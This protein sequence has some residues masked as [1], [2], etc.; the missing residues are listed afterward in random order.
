MK[1]KVDADRIINHIKYTKHWL[2]KADEDYKE[3]RFGNGAMIIGLA[4]AEL[5]AAWEEAMQLK[6]QVVRKMPRKAVRFANWKNA[7][8]VGLLASGFMIAFMISQYS[9]N[10][11]TRRENQA[12]VIKSQPIVIT[13]QAPRH[14]ASKTAHKEKSNSKKPPEQD[15]TKPPEPPT[16][17]PT[18]HNEQMGPRAPRPDRNQLNNSSRTEQPAETQAS[19]SFTDTAPE[20]PEEP[21]VYKSI[22]PTPPPAEAPRETV[23]N[24]TT[25]PKKSDLDP[26]SLFTT[27]DDSLMNSD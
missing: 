24:T 20:Q 27:A 8:A 17:P 25:Q 21:V 11:L 10:A 2:D 1:D 14:A 12:S 23:N 5:T 3:K 22:I 9:N 26:I 7:S 15:N 6:T 18:M 13:E 16:T 19:E 4:R